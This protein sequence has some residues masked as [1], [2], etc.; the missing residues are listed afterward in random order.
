MNITE[1]KAFI[2][3]Y[4]LDKTGYQI[5]Y[6]YINRDRFDFIISPNIDSQSLEYGEYSIEVSVA[7]KSLNQHETEIGWFI[8]ETII[9]ILKAQ[10]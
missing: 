5:R 1:F 7:D 8:K 6:E 9:D 4:E 3:N 10:K 2:K